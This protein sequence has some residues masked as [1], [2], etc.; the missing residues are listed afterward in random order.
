MVLSDNIADVFFIGQ[1]IILRPLT[2]DDFEQYKEVRQRCRDWLLPWEPTVN[3]VHMDT[4]STFDHFL[5]RVNAFERGSQ[6]D[7]SYGFGIFFH[8]GTFV[9]EVSLG[10]IVRGPFQSVM[11]GYWIDEKHAGKG[12]VVEATS[13]VIDYA[14][15]TLGFRRIE[16][17]IVPRNKASV[18][19]VEK[20]G[21]HYEGISKSYIEVNGVRE[22]H[23]IYSMTPEIWNLKKSV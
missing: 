23:A 14:F 7:T 10:T 19:I 6:F 17:A 21:C 18:R 22:D 3:G 12:L 20:L 2:G 11:M 8:D 15:T 9:G 4:D 13:L 5:Q 16:V 1:R